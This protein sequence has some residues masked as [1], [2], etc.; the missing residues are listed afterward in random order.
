MAGAVVTI[1]DDGKAHIE[2]GLIASGGR[3]DEES[4]SETRQFIRPG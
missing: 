4:Q 2:R 1:G 3:A